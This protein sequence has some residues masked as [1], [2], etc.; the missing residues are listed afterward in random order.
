MTWYAKWKAG[1]TRR[2]SDNGRGTMTGELYPETTMNPNSRED[3]AENPGEGASLLPIAALTYVAPSSARAFQRDLF[4]YWSTARDAPLLLTRQN[5]LY[6]KD[7]RRVNHALLQPEDLTE[8]DAAGQASGPAIDEANLPRLVFL[9]LLLTDMGLLIRRD[10]TIVAAA[11]P[12]FLDQ[13][14]GERIR[15]SFA[16]WQNGSFWNEVLSIPGIT[17]KGAGSRIDPVPGQIAHARRSVLEQIAE[18]HRSGS[19]AMWL[20]SEGTWVPIEQLVQR[21]RLADYGFLLPRDHGARPPR[22]TTAWDISAQL[23]RAE[24]IGAYSE[25]ISPRTPYISY[26][27]S[28]GWTFTPGFA[29]ESEGWPVVEGGFIRALLLEPLFWMGMVDIGYLGRKPVAYRLTPIGAWV[30]SVGPAVEIPQQEGRVIVQ[31]NF[32]IIALDPISDRTLATLDEFAERTSAE[33]AIKYRLTRHS[34]YRAQRRGWSTAR[35]IQTLNQMIQDPDP[36]AR[37]DPATRLQLSQNVVRTL[38]EWQRLHERITIHRQTTLLQAAN[39][40]LLDQLLQDPKI[41]ARVAYPQEPPPA[42]RPEHRT[43]AFITPGLNAGEALAAAL[44]DAG[45]PAARTRVHPHGIPASFSPARCIEIADDGQVLFTIALP[46][47]VLLEQLAPFTTREGPTGPTEGLSSPSSGLPARFSLTRSAIEGAIAKGM[48]ID[49]ILQRLRALHHG[50]LPRRVEIQVRAWGRY[51]GDAQMQTL[52]LLQ[53][54]D[55][56]TLRELLS[57][58]ELAELLR[59]FTPNAH[60]ALAMVPSA[61]LPRLQALLAERG[62]DVRGQLDWELPDRHDAAVPPETKDEDNVQQPDAS[63]V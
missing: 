1:D 5:R 49:Q 8:P 19:Q 20:G 33:R 22:A 32:E 43:C 4:F 42:Q 47:M 39:A 2:A 15:R 40:G 63:S 31:P 54:R 9:R 56:Q 45:Y 12:A 52:T 58:P 7:L 44:Q 25:Y 55:G 21:I 53:L 29:K 34:V 3:R 62:I 10:Q 14:P 16:H 27:N 26:G 51:Y 41:R 59:P 37:D 28:M 24:Q 36:Q 61:E 30:L 60:Q 46:S 57:E 50:P 38:E 13:E 6:R 35:I 23:L 18:L 17:A 11:Q 48:T